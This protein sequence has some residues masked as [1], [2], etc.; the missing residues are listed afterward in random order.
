MPPRMRARTLAGR[1]RIVALA[2]GLGG[3]AGCFVADFLDYVPCATSEAC[4]EV[5]L[6]ACVRLPGDAGVRG[7][8]TRGC[9]ADDACPA[10]VD[11]EGAPRCAGVD[12]RE[13]CVLSCMNGGTCPEGYVCKDISVDEGATAVCFPEAGP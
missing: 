5:G 1:R 8:C 4:A 6:D 9:S 12:A 10:G 2:L 7:F 13:V 11:G 3:A